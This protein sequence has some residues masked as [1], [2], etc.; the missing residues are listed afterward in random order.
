MSTKE[1][2]LLGD[3]SSISIMH[4]TIGLICATIVG[5]V[6]LGGIKRIGNFTSLLVPIMAAIYVFLCIIYSYNKL[7]SS[8]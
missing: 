3:V 5:S 4:V 8:W 7:R 1:V 2:A 6:I